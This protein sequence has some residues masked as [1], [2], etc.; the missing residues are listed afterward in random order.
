MLS[1]CRRNGFLQDFL[2]EVQ[3][4]FLTLLGCRFNLV[5]TTHRGKV[6]FEGAFPTFFGI[7]SIVPCQLL[8]N[9]INIS[10]KTLGYEVRLGFQEHFLALGSLDLPFLLQLGIVCG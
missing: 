9:F 1:R 8:L 7:L 10:P 5:W 3:T 2:F 4:Q 6:G